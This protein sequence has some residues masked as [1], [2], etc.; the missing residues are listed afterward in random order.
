M[1]SVEFDDEDVFQQFTEKNSLL[2]LLMAGFEP[3]VLEARSL[4]TLTLPKR[5]LVNSN[6]AFLDW[7]TSNAHPSR[8]P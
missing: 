5:F 3:K 1:S 2:N 4:P 8:L 6:S 7:L